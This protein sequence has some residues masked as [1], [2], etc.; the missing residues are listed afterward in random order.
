[1]LIAR[2]L[3]CWHFVWIVSIISE[4]V[5]VLTTATVRAGAAGAGC[6]VEAAA[7]QDL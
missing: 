7:H 4:V 2:V 1:M 6:K 3:V 5:C